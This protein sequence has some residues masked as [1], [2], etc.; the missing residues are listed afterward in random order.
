MG[1]WQPGTRDRLRAAAID[2]FV[3]QGYEQTTT[4]E[5]A[6]AGG[7]TE[8]TFFRHFAD[9]REVIFAGQEDFVGLFVDGIVRAP[10]GRTPMELA[11]A[12]LEASAAFFPDEHRDY[13]RRRMEVVTTNPALQE[14][15]LL[16]M[17]GLG[18]AVAQALRARGITEP[19]ATLAAQ[20]AV[21]VFGVAFRTWTTEGETRS[22]AEIEREVMGELGAVT[23]G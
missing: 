9:K 3:R 18:A 14:R 19:Q 4:A 11:A 1:R 10:D 12:A 8:R 20:S 21:T 17:A 7:V 5:I 16:K 13:A 23:A 6:A 2:L 15:E 22:L